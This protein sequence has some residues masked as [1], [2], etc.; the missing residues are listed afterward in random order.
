MEKLYANNLVNL[1]L[2]NSVGS[3]LD[4][5]MLIIDYL[6]SLDKDATIAKVLSHAK[7]LSLHQLNKHADDVVLN[8]SHASFNAA[9]DY[10]LQFWDTQPG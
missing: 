5:D 7:A 2:K 4:Y 3:K 1:W 6:E 8:L 10:Q 9:I